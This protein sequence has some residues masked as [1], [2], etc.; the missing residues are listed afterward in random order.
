MRRKLTI[1]HLLHESKT[2][3]FIDVPYFDAIVVRLPE[4][5]DIAFDVTC[6]EVLKQLKEA[7]MTKFLNRKIEDI[8]IEDE[9]RITRCLIRWSFFTG[10]VG[11]FAI[12]AVVTYLAFVTKE[13]P[14][15]WLTTVLVAIPAGIMWSQAGVLKQE[16]AEG[17][18]R[19]LGHLRPGFL[20]PGRRSFD[21]HKEEYYEDEYASSKRHRHHVD[22]VESQVDVPPPPGNKDRM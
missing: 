1:R 5:M 20:K 4:E 9:G 7:G 2:L 13:M 16:N 12:L 6:E 22:D 14:D 17:L 8:L 3:K 19:I 15:L 11:S 18:G 21:D 10:I